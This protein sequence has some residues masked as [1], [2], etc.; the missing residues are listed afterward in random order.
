MEERNTDLSYTLRNGPNQTC[1]QLVEIKR[2]FKSGF[3]VTSK[4]IPENSEAK[5]QQSQI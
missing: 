2:L 3:R 4:F 5:I 1:F